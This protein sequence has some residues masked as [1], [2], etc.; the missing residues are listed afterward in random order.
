MKR[1]L[2]LALILTLPLLI[3]SCAEDEEE[4]DT[5]DPAASSD[6]VDLGV[7][8]FYEAMGTEGKDFTASYDLFEEAVRLNPNNMD[9]HVGAGV[10]NILR[11]PNHPTVAAVL[12]SLGVDVLVKTPLPFPWGAA[13]FSDRRTPASAA[14]QMIFGGL[15]GTSVVQMDFHLLL[16]FIIG[17]IQVSINHFDRVENQP[18]YAWLFP[19]MTGTGPD[20]VEID[21]TDIHF[22]E[23]SLHL[24]KAFL[25]GLNAYEMEM[26]S[27][28][29]EGLAGALSPES[30]FMTLTDPAALATAQAALGEGA[31]E[32]HTGAVLLEAEEDDQTD[33]LIRLEM[34]GDIPGDWPTLTEGQR[35]SLENMPTIM[36]DL[37]DNPM[38]IVENFDLN[39]GTPDDTLMV[40]LGV[41]FEDPILDWK[42]I[43]PDYEIVLCP[44]DTTF[45]INWAAATVDEW[46]WQP[47]SLHG[48][49][50][51]P[52]RPMT[53]EDMRRIFGLDA[54]FLLGGCR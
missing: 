18:D 3:G 53:S 20:T 19:N 41:L 16:D 52:D 17:V 26:S 34:E 7:F 31:D 25:L 49:L 2:A 24:V 15:S 54:M 5:I 13:G 35:D 39:E 37:M 8:A 10:T 36:E 11:L 40:S 45:G 43:L 28:D 47:D 38:E 23:S 4:E 12:E 22:A 48:L 30:D 1:V 50:A 33:D 46:A 27:L 9:A 14:S 29:V 51:L 44:G 32:V 6:K 21:V 42:A